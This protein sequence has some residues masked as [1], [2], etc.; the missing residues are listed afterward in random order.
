M[1]LLTVGMEDVTTDVGVVGIRF[2][3]ED[4]PMGSRNV[5]DCNAWK[6]GH[7]SVEMNYGRG[8]GSTELVSKNITREAGE[9]TTHPAS[10]TVVV[11]RACTPGVR[12]RELGTNRA[13]KQ[14][15]LVAAMC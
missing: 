9:G 4:A 10:V 5:V 6:T 15:M 7:R 8:G 1:V 3:R 2:V 11:A 13:A 12:L 14:S